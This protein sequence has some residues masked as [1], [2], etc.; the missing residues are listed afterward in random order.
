MIYCR[1][2]IELPFTEGERERERRERERERERELQNALFIV[3]FCRRN[4]VEK[5]RNIKTKN[6]Q[7]RKK[8]I[9]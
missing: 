5:F 6:I 4:I 3:N 9:T 2:E 1:K 7:S 8:R